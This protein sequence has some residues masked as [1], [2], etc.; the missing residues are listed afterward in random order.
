MN[1]TPSDLPSIS[2]EPVSVEP[3]GADGSAKGASPLL[4]P[5]IDPWSFHSGMKDLFPGGEVG[6][7]TEIARGLE[8]L[9]IPDLKIVS[10]PGLLDFYSRDQADVPE[11]LRDMLFE[12]VPDAVLQPFAVEAIPPVLRY[13]TKRR[14][15][16]VVRGAGSSPFG[17]SMPVT[18]GIV[19]DMNALDCVLRFDSAQR[20]VKVQAGMRWADLDWFL[21]QHGLCVPCT[22]SSRFST[23][24]G[25]VATGGIGIASIS[26]GHL[27]RSVLELEV[28]DC[29]GVL[30]KLTPR[31]RDFKSLFGSEGQLAVIA[32]VTLQAKAKPASPAPR[33]TLFPDH[34]SA[35][36]YSIGL[37]SAAQRPMD[38]T[39]FSPAKF[40]ALNRILGKD[41][42]PVAHGVLSCY[43]SEEDPSMKNAPPLPKQARPAHQYLAHLLWN[44][45]F[46][47][48]K[49]RKLGPGLMG[50]EVLAPRAHLVDIVAKAEKV[51]SSH[52]IEPMIEIHFLEGGD[53]MLLCYYITDQARQLKYTMDSF[54]GLLITSALLD[55]GARPYSFGVWNHTFSDHADPEEQEE[56]ARAKRYLDPGS[57]MNQGKSPR[58]RGRWG[59]VPATLFSPGILGSALKLVNRF[60]FVAAEAVKLVSSSNA[61]DRQDKEDI[62]LRTADEC[63][64]CGACIGV[65][66]AYLAT[67]DERVTARG[68]LL[69]A[70][71][72]QN[73]GKVTKEHARRTFLC[74]RCKAC[75]QVCQSKLSLIPVY[76]ELERRLTEVYGK[77]EEEIKLFVE[78]VENSPAYDALVDR[79]LVLGA[80][81]KSLE[82][83]K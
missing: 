54:R 35:L 47:P 42:F 67:K 45:R 63:A 16:I 72:M 32:S 33:L 56:R 14:I 71:Q 77:N 30:R 70:R 78:Q 10:S 64:M 80:A 43:E 48:M 60:G 22:P 51:C 31:D 73:G 55:A 81:S 46:F 27:S 8:A 4:T 25:W 6:Q 61:F 3:K 65:C 58:L 13:A 79:G 57:I 68:K 29:E 41:Y 17:G 44:E 28:I 74:L 2:E 5:T 53:G 66:P 59:G 19:L 76:D 50:A 18:G 12:S 37:A 34:A 40:D 20:T 7:Q 9:H 69:T 23:V 38:L 1:T 52:D 26:A 36:N 62:L 39:Y 75:E 82:G 21:E 83:G 11:F 24:G 15:P 49:F